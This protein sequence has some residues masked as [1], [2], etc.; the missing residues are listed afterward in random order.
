[1]AP[2]ENEILEQASRK[3]VVGLRYLLEVDQKRGVVPAELCL[4]QQ[5]PDPPLVVMSEKLLV[6][7]PL[8]FAK[9]RTKVFAPKARWVP[10]LGSC[11]RNPVRNAG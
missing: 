9:L 1:M 11:L 5:V 7:A 3:V 10:S 4:N 8:N 2:A 6:H